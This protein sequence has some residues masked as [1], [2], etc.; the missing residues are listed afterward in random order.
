MEWARLI[1]FFVDNKS[2]PVGGL[3]SVRWVTYYILS[4]DL[5]R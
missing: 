3:L 2:N 4:M 5:T 1:P